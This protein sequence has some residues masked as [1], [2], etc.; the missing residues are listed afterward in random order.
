MTMRTLYRDM[1]EG[2]TLSLD[3]GR[4]LITLEE[5]SGHK[6][7]LKFEAEESVS[8]E[9]RERDRATG[10]PTGARQARLGIKFAA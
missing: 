9:R 7:K 5:K 8:I 10:I 6:A 3:G 1:R 4:I 2:Q